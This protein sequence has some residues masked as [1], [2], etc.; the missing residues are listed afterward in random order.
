[1]KYK[2]RILFGTDYEPR[3]KNVKG[4]YTTHYRFL[5]TKDEYF[6]HPF[7]FLGPWKIYGVGLPDDVLRFVYHDNAA[8]VLG[9]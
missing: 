3:I 5:E 7:D 1:M 9:L 2:N 6:D 4:F 8:R